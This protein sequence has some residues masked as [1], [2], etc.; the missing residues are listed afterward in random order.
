MNDLRPLPA[1]QQAIIAKCHHPSGEWIEFPL[2][3]LDRSLVTRFEEMVARNPDRLALKTDDQEFTYAELN[4]AVNQVAHAILRVAPK[5]PPC[6][7]LLVEHGAAAVIAILAVLK[8]GSAYLPLDPAFPLARNRAILREAQPDLLLTNSRNWALAGSLSVGRHQLLNMDDAAS[9]PLCDNPGLPI[10]PDALCHILYTSGSTGHPR[11]VIHNHRNQLHCILQNSN[12]LHICA[13]D[14]L[15]LFGSYSTVAGAYSIFCALLNGAALFPYAIQ[16]KGVTGLALWLADNAITFCDLVPTAFRQI[17]D[18]LAADQRL[19][20]L[21]LLYLGGERVD[22]EDIASYKRCLAPTA[23]LATGLAAT[24]TCSEVCLM[25]IDK[26]TELTERVVPVGYAMP[27]MTVC[28]VD[29]ARQPTGPNRIGE[30]AVKSPYLALGYWQRPDLTSTRFLPATDDSQQRV[31]L[32]GDLGLLR[33]DGAILHKGRNDFQLKIR[34]NRVDIGEIE[35][36]LLTLDWVKQAAVAGVSRQSGDDA[37]VAYLVLHDGLPQQNLPTVSQL[38]KALTGHLPA[39]MIPAQY[40]FMSELPLTVTGK[41]DR[42]ALPAAPAT[43]PGLDTAYLA[44]RTPIETTVAA[45]WGA[46]LEMTQVG[47]DDSFLELGGS[48]LQ[49]MRIVARVNEE[50][51]I[52]CTLAELFAASTGT[53]TVAEMALVIVAKL[54]TAIDLRTMFEGKACV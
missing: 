35:A 23:I 24:E 30:I 36:A 1:W 14:R 11:G 45:L 2:S 52:N 8:A 17:V 51:G 49:A 39:Y 6:M 34:G 21:R 12:R 50:F 9:N 5:P 16:E 4:A 10:G 37:L 42:T 22:P 29:E 48:S 32:T 13:Q 28:L 38:R 19:P 43:R 27:G 18:T 40:V 31:Y 20:Q 26:E 33:A 15:P 3:A 53:A 25:L 44:P 54:T 7:A 47:I 41:I 46:T